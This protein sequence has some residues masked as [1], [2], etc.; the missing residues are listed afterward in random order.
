[1]NPRNHFTVAEVSSQAEETEE[2]VDFKQETAITTSADEVAHLSNIQYTMAVAK[3]T[4]ISMIAVV[5]MAK[6]K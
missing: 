5:I 1:M 3:V 6:I 2:E 4:I